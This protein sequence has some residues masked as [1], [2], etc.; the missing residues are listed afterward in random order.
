MSDT[1]VW[2]DS[3]DKNM[4]HLGVLSIGKFCIWATVFSDGMYDLFGDIDLSKIASVPV[5]VKLS[6]RVCYE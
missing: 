5:P 1:F 6:L 3:Y 2:Q 4:Y